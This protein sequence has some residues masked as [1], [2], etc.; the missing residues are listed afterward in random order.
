MLNEKPFEKN[1]EVELLA[2][3]QAA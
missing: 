2:S 1:G 3:L